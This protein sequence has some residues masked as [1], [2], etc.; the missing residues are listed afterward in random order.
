MIARMMQFVSKHLEQS[1]VSVFLGL[2]HGITIRILCVVY[3][4]FSAL[5]RHNREGSALFRLGGGYSAL[6]DALSS[7][8]VR[9]QR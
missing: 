9:F 5:I 2:Y 1:L 7:K 4:V 8:N 6:K 3:V